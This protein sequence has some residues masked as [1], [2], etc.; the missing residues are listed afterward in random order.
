MSKENKIRRQINCFK[1]INNQIKFEKDN[2][3]FK[4]TE[5]V[6]VLKFIYLSFDSVVLE[7]DFVCALIQTL[8]ICKTK[9]QKNVNRLKIKTFFNNEWNV[10]F[11]NVTVDLKP[12]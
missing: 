12:F 5:I 10:F 11:L 3:R 1:S 6:S 2:L 7:F 4:K 8:S 9:R